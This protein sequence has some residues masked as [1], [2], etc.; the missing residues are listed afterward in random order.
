MARQK[1]ILLDNALV[2]WANAIRYCDQILAGK[3][4]L[5]VRKNFVS[6]LHN[7]VELFFKQIMLDNCDYR[8]AEPRTV[9]AD[10]EPAKTFYAATDL[11]AYFEHLDSDTRNKFISIEFSNLVGKHKKLLGS[12]MQSNMPFTNELNLLNSLRNNETHFYIGWDEYLT[13]GEFCMLHNFMVTFYQVLH[14]YSLLPFWG[15]PDDEH[16]RLSFERTPLKSFSYKNAIRNSSTAK[17]IK[18]AADGMVFE[19]YGPFT[20]YA[21][22]SAIASKTQDISF[23]EIWAYVEVLDQLGMIELVQTGEIEYDNPEYGH[24]YCA[25]PT[26]TR[27]EFEIHVTL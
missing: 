9:E 23:D 6:S 8:V 22:T 21:M 12:F 2:A 3:I 13:E 19:D 4:T 16:L 11:N 14:D 15:E 20:V 27:V 7:A 10:G 18:D 17:A 24:D 1:K 5:E 25:P 26:I